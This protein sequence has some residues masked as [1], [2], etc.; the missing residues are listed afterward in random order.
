MEQNRRT[1]GNGT[2]LR[3]H[4]NLKQMQQKNKLT[5]IILVT[6]VNKQRI[7]VYT[8]LRVEPKYWDKSI[9]R[10]NTEHSMNLRERNRL[11]Q[12]NRQ[13][14][15]L[16]NSI[17]QADEKLAAKGKY[18]SLTAVRKVV[19]ENQP[20]VQ[21]SQT[22]IAYLY[23]QIEEYLKNVNRRGK[24]GIASTQRT[25]LTALNRLEQFCTL[26]Q[27]T[28]KTFEDFDKRF[29]AD[30]TNYLYTCSYQKGNMKRQYTQNTVIN[31]LKV[32]KNLLHRAYDNE[33]TDNNSFTKVQTTLSADV[34]EQ[35]YLEEKE[36]RKL[37]EVKT[38][39]LQETHVRDM[40]IIACY[41]AL[42]ISDIQKLDEAII[43]NGFISLYQTKTKEQVEIPILKERAPLI[44]SY[45]QS[46]FPRINIYQANKIIKVLAK[47]CGFCQP[48]NHKEYRGGTVHVK[49]Q[50]KWEMLCFHTARRSCITNLYK[51]GY[52]V[53]Y[54][55]TLSGHRSI[56]AFQR[57]M[58]ATSKELITSF[59]NLLRK[60]R[61][62]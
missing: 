62:L 54:I 42:R 5:Q 9:H 25:Y 46:G 31:T 41:T 40:F 45:R 14:C 44:N 7:R 32:V 61:A 49:T 10:C 2:S 12:I 47:R 58:K 60:D 15:L 20:K 6:T 24:R 36:I 39:T 13:L 30:F 8:K 26:T 57:Y 16:E 19:E 34:S 27:R 23:T 17:H 11:K 56:Q 33:M 51:R 59:V 3:L 55:M 1:T 43:C 37:A 28:I 50:A 53:N 35:V 52:P 22:P 38:F 18:L 29:F 21:T 4:F 48:I